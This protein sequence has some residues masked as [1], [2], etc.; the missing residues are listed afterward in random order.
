MFQ[1]TIRVTDDGTLALSADQTF[2]VTVDE[3]NAAPALTAIGDKTVD[4]LSELTFV[5]TASDPN[6]SPPNAV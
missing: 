4:E 1:I 2:T 5:A 3:V 6:D